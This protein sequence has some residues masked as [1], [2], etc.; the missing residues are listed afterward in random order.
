VAR[1]D[2][3]AIDDV[4]VTLVP[5]DVTIAHVPEHSTMFLLGSGLVGLVG[6]GRRRFLK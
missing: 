1:D 4:R 3:A 5:E 2:S 6:Y